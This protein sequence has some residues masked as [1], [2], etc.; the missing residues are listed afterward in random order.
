MLYEFT[1]NLGWWSY[2][3]NLVTA[4]KV[5]DHHFQHDGTWSTSSSRD[6]GNEEFQKLF[7]I[8]DYY[9]RTWRMS[10]EY[11]RQ[12]WLLCLWKIGTLRRNR[13]RRKNLHKKIE[14]R[15][16]SHEI[17]VSCWCLWI[18]PVGRDEETTS[19]YTDARTWNATNAFHYSRTDRISHM[20]SL[21]QSWYLWCQG[22]VLLKR[23]PG[24]GIGIATTPCSRPQRNSKKMA[25][26]STTSPKNCWTHRNA[27]H[28]YCEIM[29][30]IIEIHI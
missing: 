30:R 3:P 11:P 27:S 7:H 26:P 17:L 2:G 16:A 22:N 23:A 4:H 24:W 18:R 6:N 15:E 21:S 10:L 28:M 1:L 5:W 25:M 12:C 19:S 20:D 9:K 29:E 8:A 14:L 13:R